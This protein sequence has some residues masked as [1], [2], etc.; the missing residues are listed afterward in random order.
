[1]LQERATLKHRNG[2]KGV[3]QLAR[4]ANKNKDFKKMYEEQ[5]RLGREL[6]EKHGRE[7]GSDSD[8]ESENRDAVKLT[9]AEM[10]E[11]RYFCYVESQFFEEND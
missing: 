10:L 8:S 11:V 3:Q 6:A 7:K 4:Y 9:S 2:G 5:I 1:M